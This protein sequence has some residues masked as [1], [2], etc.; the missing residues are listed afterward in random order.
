MSLTCPLSIVVTSYEYRR[1][2]YLSNLI[3]SLAL[4]D[5]EGFE[6]VFVIESDLLLLDELKNVIHNAGLRNYRILFNTDRPGISGS[7]NLGMSATIGDIIALVDDDVVLPCKWVSSVVRIFDDTSVLAATG[8]VLPDWEDG[9]WSWLP[10]EFH[11]LIG[12]STWSQKVKSF[13]V[14]NVWGANMA[15]RREAVL[16]I[17]GFSDQVGGMHGERVYG[18]ENEVS[19]RLTQYRPGRII[20]APEMEVRH[21]IYSD[22]LNL[23]RILSNSFDMGKSRRI[24]AGNYRRLGI[25]RAIIVS[26]VVQRMLL[27]CFRLPRRRG[28]GWATICISTITLVSGGIGFATGR[29]PNSRASIAPGQG[30]R[31]E[32]EQS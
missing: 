24:Y 6:V 11:W 22:K 5:F 3:A 8:P 27:E 4:Q 17:S 19:I 12:C 10:A 21:R 20:L 29:A 31:M 7:R 2:K 28:K 15:F 25:E 9:E 14:R 32:V 26:I 13:R 30:S 1:L 18:E 23:R 16:A